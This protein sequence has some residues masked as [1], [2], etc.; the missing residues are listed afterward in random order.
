MQTKTAF[1][2]ITKVGVTL[3]TSPEKSHW[4]TRA[5]PGVNGSAFWATMKVGCDGAVLL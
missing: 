4:S 1:G 5:S 2:V 3:D